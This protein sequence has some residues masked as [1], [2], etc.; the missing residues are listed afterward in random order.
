MFG[1]MGQSNIQR[2]IDYKHGNND[3]KTEGKDDEAYE[4][5]PQGF[6]LGSETASL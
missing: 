6:I 3:R 4:K 5:F 1:N 2:S